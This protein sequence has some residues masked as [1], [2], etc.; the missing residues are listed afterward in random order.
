MVSSRTQSGFAARPLSASH[1][2]AGVVTLEE[3]ASHSEVDLVLIATSGKAD[4]RPRWPQSGRGRSA[5]AN[6]EV[7]VMAGAL[8]MT[9]ARK[10]RSEDQAGGQ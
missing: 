5:L 3:M 4:W 2:P 1:I 10:L 7:L 8:V 9:E 6:K